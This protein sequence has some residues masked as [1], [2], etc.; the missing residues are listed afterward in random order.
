MILTKVILHQGLSRSI[1]RAVAAPEPMRALKEERW[2]IGGSCGDPYDNMSHSIVQCNYTL[3][4]VFWYFVCNATATSYHLRHFFEMDV[5][6]PSI[7]KTTNT[8]NTSSQSISETGRMLQVGLAQVQRKVVSSLLASGLCNHLCSH[9]P[10]SVIL[11][12]KIM[13]IIMH[14]MNIW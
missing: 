13:L 11:K 4:N 3:D 8:S 1:P 2:K 12:L 6:S 10:L 9:N 5:C 7:A 14:T